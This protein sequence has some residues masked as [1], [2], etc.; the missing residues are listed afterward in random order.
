M[1]TV[2]DIVSGYG[3]KFAQKHSLDELLA[4]EA[5]AE[6]EATL[7]MPLSY[8]GRY[9]KNVDFFDGLTSGKHVALERFR[10]LSEYFIAL[11]EESC[12]ISLP[13]TITLS[14]FVSKAL[15]VLP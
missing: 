4:W 3:D 5:S 12:A 8:L 15:F 7:N 1:V 11:S 13:Y 9:R 6:D 2:Q 10:L 14:S